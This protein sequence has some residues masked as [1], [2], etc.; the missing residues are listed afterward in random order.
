M[1]LSHSLLAGVV[2]A[3]AGFAAQAAVTA[4]EAKA[5]GTTLTPV[6]A[7]KSANKDGT[8]PAY[9]GG[10]KSGPAGYKGGDGI[11]PDPFASEKPRLVIDAKNMAEH[12]DKLTD[13]T[14]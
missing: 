14:K 3:S 1:K 13:G 9:T 10:M 8:I 6:G 11:R 2:A 4:D 5:L 7:D 12:A